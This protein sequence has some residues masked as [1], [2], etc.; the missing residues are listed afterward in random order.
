MKSITQ[1]VLAFILSAGQVS[2]VM[3]ADTN[4]AFEFFQEEAK[5]VSA[6]RI[7]E[8][9]SLAPATT[10]VVTSEDIHA[11]GAQNIWDALRNVPGV[12]VMETRAGQA[13]VGNPGRK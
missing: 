1:S 7:P 3:A 11:S 9:R 5:V 10:Y 2:S 13:E 4:D 12:D 6:S 8:A